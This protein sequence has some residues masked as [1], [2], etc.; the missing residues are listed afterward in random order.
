MTTKSTIKEYDYNLWGK[1]KTI[2]DVPDSKIKHFKKFK[3]I[4][5]NKINKRPGGYISEVQ[6][7]ILVAVSKDMNGGKIC[8]DHYIKTKIC[9]KVFYE[10]F[11]L[12]KNL[13]CLKSTGKKASYIKY[14]LSNKG[15]ILKAEWQKHYKGEGL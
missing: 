7:N 1:L 9:K 8:H 13:D 6:Y 14:K 5:N 4:D 3:I 10:N 12:L 2:K 15:I 11:S